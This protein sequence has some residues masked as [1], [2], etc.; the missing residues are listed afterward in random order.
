MKKKDSWII[1]VLIFAVLFIV[2]T[3]LYEQLKEKV[4]PEAGVTEDTTE[5]P[6]EETKDLAPDF[7]VYDAKGNEVKLSDFRGKPVV[8]NF[9]A[10]W[11]GPCKREMPDFQKVYEAYGEEVHFV[12]V[13]LTDGVQETVEAASQFME[14]NGYTF[15]VYF[16]TELIAANAYVVNSVPRTYFI[17]AEG[18][19]VD[20]VYG[21]INEEY[22]MNGIEKL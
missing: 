21:A 2:A 18:F 20:G 16:D 4:L 9:W 10:S 12:M 6:N 11:C 1:Y 13:N 22:L 17:D 8:L 7:V 19:L 15:P 5:T 14:D 3:A